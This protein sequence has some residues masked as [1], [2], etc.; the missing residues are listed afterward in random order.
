MQI[1]NSKGKHI[2]FK[3]TL[4]IFLIGLPHH[5]Y[6]K[7]FLPKKKSQPTQLFFFPKFFPVHHTESLSFQ[8]TLPKVSTSYP[9]LSKAFQ[10]SLQLQMFCTSVTSKIYLLFN[11]SIYLIFSLTSLLRTSAC[12]PSLNHQI[13]IFFLKITPTKSEKSAASHKS[14]I[15]VY[16]SIKETKMN[17]YHKDTTALQANLSKLNTYRLQTI[18]AQ[19]CK[20]K[21]TGAPLLPHYFL[22]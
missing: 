22:I 10:V 19:F 18:K 9:S 3:V 4:S 8:S 17:V 1:N 7:P 16:S 20:A 15:Y 6:E 13:L 11:Y 21:L 12:L 14:R 2:K 5:I